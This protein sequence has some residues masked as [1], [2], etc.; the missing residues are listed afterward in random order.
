MNGKYIEEEIE[1]LLTENYKQYYRLAYS[2]V[3]NEQDAL[4]IVQES[5]YKAIK[6]S[7]KIKRGEYAATWIYRIVVNTSMDFLRKRKPDIAYEE[8]EGVF[9][10]EEQKGVDVLEMLKILDKKEQ[11]ILILRYFE[12]R[13]LEEIADILGE[14]LNTVKAKLYRSL[15]KLKA[16]FDNPES[17]GGKNYV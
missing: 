14:N 10:Q 15:K 11:T 8:Q 3:K 9:H 5:A 13:K 17:E 2:Y 4:D 12:E 6:N 16:D 1:R 7:H